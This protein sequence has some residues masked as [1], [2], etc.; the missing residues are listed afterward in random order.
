[1]PPAE[2]YAN[3]EGKVFNIVYTAEVD[4]KDY[5]LT[6]SGTATSRCLVALT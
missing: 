6:G 4:G 3:P 5:P 1:M 2:A